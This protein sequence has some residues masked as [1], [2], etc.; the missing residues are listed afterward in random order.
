MSESKNAPEKW[1]SEA[2][3][4]A[5]RARLA[6]LKSKDGGKKPIRFNS[7]VFRLVI[8][9]ILVVALLGTGAWYG[10]R[11]G[12]PARTLTAATIG[13]EKIKGTELNFYFYSICSQYGLDP[14]TDEGKAMLKDDSGM[15]EFKTLAD[16]IKDSA[17]KEAQNIV[18][19]WSKAKAAGLKL[20]SDDQKRID[21][22][23]S[24]AELQATSQGDKLDNL[25]A[26]TFGAGMSKAE[27]QPILERILLANQF[28]QKTVDEMNFTSAELAAHYEANKND[29]D[30]VTYRQ[31]YVAADY[32]TDATDE[33][34]AEAMKAAKAKAEQMLAE[35]KDDETFKAAAITYATD[36]EK[37]AYKTGDPTLIKNVS[38]SG[39][40]T[41]EAGDW[42]FDS[43]R[44]AGDKL[45]SEASSGYYVIL[46]KSKSRP[47]FNQISVRHILIDS[48]RKNDAADVIAT[49]KAE[50]EKIL[51][52]YLAG[53]K[54]AD[55]FGKLAAANSTDTGSATNGGLYE[56][57]KPG[58]MVE[59][60]DAWCFDPARKP[61]DT[62]IVQTDYG[63]HIMYFEKVDGV[64]W[65]I[66]VKEK[67]KSD[68]YDKFITDE[69]A[70]FPYTLN[71]LGM[72]FVG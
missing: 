45:V 64:D 55:A 7:P 62:G 4:E 9:I 3:R 47:D 20:T 57:V 50:A 31:F 13:S 70:K 41:N 1:K 40:V 26:Q 44:K 39:I 59:E 66:Q 8:V 69:T 60:F 21:D 19:L 16:Y 34:K 5:R 54:T 53:E 42:S 68:A 48:D 18:M 63:F 28:S 27:L 43:A 17:A 12:L 38:L 29:Y 11:L 46:F 14:T 49:A 71:K 10:I 2:S 67:L 24:Q 23:F 58:A 72:A 61:G 22:Y 32:A 35:V 56:G 51:A 33:V 37:D 65:E 6:A 52:G 25:L 15:D 36:T 30:V